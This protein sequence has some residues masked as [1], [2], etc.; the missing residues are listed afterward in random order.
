MRSQQWLFSS[1]IDDICVQFYVFS[2]PSVLESRNAIVSANRA[3]LESFICGAS[4][5][6]IPSTKGFGID[7][8]PQKMPIPVLGRTCKFLHASIQK[9]IKDAYSCMH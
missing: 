7:S 9:A 4:S 2:V 8:D 1:A 3:K 6:M 5:D